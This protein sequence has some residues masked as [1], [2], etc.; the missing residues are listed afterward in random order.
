MQFLTCNRGS[1]TSRP[2]VQINKSTQTNRARSS[3]TPYGYVEMW[4]ITE[5]KSETM[6]IRYLNNLVY[7]YTFRYFKGAK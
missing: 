4:Q 7:F 2:K 3:Y 5:T 1:T 6:F